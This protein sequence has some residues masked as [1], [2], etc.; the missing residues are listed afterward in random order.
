M[1]PD[2]PEKKIRAFVAIHPDR[3]TILELERVQAELRRELDSNGIRWAQSGQLHLTLQFLGYIPSSRLVDFEG[4]MAEAVSHHPAFNLRAEA[5]GCF[6]NQK[7][8]RILWAG[9][10]G[11][12]DL[13]QKLKSELDQKL[14]PLGFKP[15]ERAFHPHV[16]LARIEHLKIR[17]IEEL[18][19]QILSYQAVRFGAWRVEKLDLMRSV[20]S[21]AGAGYSLLKSFALG[22]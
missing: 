17:E 3:D 6:P 18:G 16:T 21:S 12:L 9:L 7:K 10:N 8:P 1:N 5:L 2:E 15:E 4:V 22:Q 13:L 19:R 20:L 14:T 11:E